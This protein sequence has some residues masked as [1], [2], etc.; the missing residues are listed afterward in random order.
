MIIPP[1]KICTGS[2]STKKRLLIASIGIPD[3]IKKIMIVDSEK[4][5]S[6]IEYMENYITDPLYGSF[7]EDETNHKYKYALH[8]FGYDEKEGI[9]DISDNTSGLY[10]NYQSGPVLK[11]YNLYRNNP[12]I[13]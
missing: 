9:S 12:Y 5:F 13:I 7:S 6:S 1:L 10:D 2:K 8:F 3:D 4:E 11:A